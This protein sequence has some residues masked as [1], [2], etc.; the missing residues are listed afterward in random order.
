MIIPLTTFMKMFNDNR[1]TSVG[2]Q[3][4][5][6]SPPLMDATRDEVR[7]LMHARGGDKWDQKDGFPGIVGSGAI[8]GLWQQLTGVVAMV[9]QASPASSWW[10]AAL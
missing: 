6:R 10:W 9:A 4:Q 8:M 7:L 2:L 5:A 1:F 3:I